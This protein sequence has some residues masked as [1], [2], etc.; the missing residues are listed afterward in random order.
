MND[1]KSTEQMLT[2]NI[3]VNLEH[4]IE[5]CIKHVVTSIVQERLK[6]LIEDEIQQAL[7][8]EVSKAIEELVKVEMKTK[9][10]KFKYDG[11]VESELSL[12]D[13]VREAMKGIQEQGL[14]YQLTKVD[15]Y[16]RA[17][18]KTALSSVIEQHIYINVEKRLAPLWKKIEDDFSAKS[19]E[20]L[21]TFAIKAVERSTKKVLSGR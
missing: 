17:T 11:A 16:G 12:E 2:F 1:K 8:N 15:S 13:V 5:R 20:A 4:D 6:A 10:K 14:S 3:P 19:T 21:T 18:Q 9:I 7:R